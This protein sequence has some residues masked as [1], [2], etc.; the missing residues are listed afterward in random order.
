MTWT[1]GTLL[2]V[3]AMF[4]A[5]GAGMLLVGYEWGKESRDVERDAQDIIHQ[6]ACHHRPDGN[7]RTLAG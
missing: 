6:C 2:I 7:G 5:F 1:I 3:A 4:V